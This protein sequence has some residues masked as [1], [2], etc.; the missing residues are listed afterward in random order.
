MRWQGGGWGISG[1]LRYEWTDFHTNGFNAITT[2][3]GV[4]YMPTTASSSYGHLLPSVTGYYNIT[5]DMRVR[6]A[7]SRT[8]G[9]PKFTDMGL[10][11]G[12]LNT[13]DASNPTLKVGNPNLRPRV[14]DNLDL[15][16]EWYLDGGQG[17]FTV[18][19]FHKSIENEIYLL[20]RNAP[21]DIGGGT[22]ANGTITSPVNSS[23][24]TVVD[25]L[26]FNLIK[27]F[28]FLPGELSHFGVNANGIWSHAEV[29]VLLADGGQRQ[30]NSLPN[31]AKLVTNLALF[32]ENAG[33]YG[34]LAWNHT[35]AFIED[36]FVGTGTASAADF[37]RIRW[38][39]PTDGLDASLSY[40][41]D[42]TY[43]V[44]VDGTNLTNVGVNTNIGVNREIPLARMKIPA[45]VL[46]G[47][48][49]KL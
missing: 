4:N 24:I 28:D 42:G 8:I 47:V 18:G 12:A 26:E 35:G 22:M 11:G 10:L 23:R 43:T 41:I 37:Y 45:A 1:G 30:F 36:R 31:Q 49:A 14:S 13:T 6:A 2:K 33:W 29:P 15:A 34:R 5:S 44:R 25:G 46:F 3:T 16:Y 21:I 39:M 40:D 38:T 7:Y 20:G 32:Y 19:L 9:R 27:Y 48:S 17:M